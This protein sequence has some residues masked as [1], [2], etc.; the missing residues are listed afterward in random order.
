MT[1]GSNKLAAAAAIA[2]AAEHVARAEQALNDALARADELGAEVENIEQRL[3]AVE[4]RRGD[5]RADLEAGQLTDRE[6]GGLLSLVAEDDSDLRTLLAEAVA[7]AK[8]AEPIAENAALKTAQ[9]ALETVKA[10]AE[11]DALRDHIRQAE[12]A[13]VDGLRAAGPLLR[14]LGIVA[15]PARVWSP[16]VQLREALNFSRLPV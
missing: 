2:S 5:I 9:Q 7:A 15:S 14:R 13:L 11:L 4:Q 12:A 10:E 3:V 1:N 8:G 6:A 16:T